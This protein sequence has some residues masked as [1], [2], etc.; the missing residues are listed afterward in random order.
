[1]NLF[2]FFF[3]FFFALPVLPHSCFA[4]FS[5]PPHATTTKMPCTGKVKGSIRSKNFFIIVEKFFRDMFNASSGGRGKNGN[6]GITTY[7]CFPSCKMFNFFVFVPC[8]K[9]FSSFSHSLMNCEVMNLYEKALFCV[10]SLQNNQYLS[11]GIY[12]KK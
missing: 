11:C 8:C 10:P 3:P 5:S 2:P 4:S 12:S 1:V 7:F 9:Y 6:E